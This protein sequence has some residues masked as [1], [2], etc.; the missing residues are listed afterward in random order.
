[1]YSYPHLIF[2]SPSYLTDEQIR[3]KVKE[4]TGEY[5]QNSLIG[6][7]EH[8]RRKEATIITSQWE[9]NEISFAVRAK[10]FK[11]EQQVVNPS[12]ADYIPPSANVLTNQ[13]WQK[14]NIK[15]EDFCTIYYETV[16]DLLDD[17]KKALLGS[18]HNENNSVQ[19][20]NY[21]EL[22]WKIIDKDMTIFPKNALQ[23]IHLLRDCY[24]RPTFKDIGKKGC[25]QAGTLRSRYISLEFFIHYLQKN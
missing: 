15:Y 8:T 7:T 20:R 17:F 3:A 19:H 24:H 10:A 22:I 9:E 23:N 18:G 16:K 5:W 4:L 13:H 11:P 6:E 2:I 1:M 21:V 14:W 25:V 12:S